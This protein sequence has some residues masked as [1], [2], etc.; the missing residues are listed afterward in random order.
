MD[1]KLSRRS[2]SQG[3]MVQKYKP[4]EVVM[5]VVG[6]SKVVKADEAVE[7]TLVSSKSLW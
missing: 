5:A 4:L 2:V 3:L 7:M 1:T 6:Q